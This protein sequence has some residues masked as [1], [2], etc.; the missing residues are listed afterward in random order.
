M[1]RPVSCALTWVLRALSPTW[2]L[3]DSVKRNRKGANRTKIIWRFNRCYLAGAVVLSVAA[4]IWYDRI[5]LQAGETGSWRFPVA[6]LL[7]SR[8]IEVFVAFYRDAMAKLKS[9]PSDSNLSPAQRV[10]LALASYA[11]IILDFALLYSFFP[12]T[13]WQCGHRP[14][15]MVVLISY[16]ATTITTS[17]GGALQA[18]H[19][20][21]QTVTAF[22]IFTGVILLIVCFAVYAAQAN[23][24]S[25]S[26]ASLRDRYRRRRR[27]AVHRPRSF[28]L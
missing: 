8:C 1:A 27:G 7:L 21:L 17:G 23:G 18:E 22:E 20:S 9:R 14:S 25:P 10:N 19:W 12:Q 3:A 6:W 2:W 4:L 15:S 5:G 11:E 28:H 26:R 24:P 16:S 13:A